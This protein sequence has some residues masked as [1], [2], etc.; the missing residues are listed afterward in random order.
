MA[1]SKL[2]RGM[3]RDGS[4]RVLVIDSTEIVRSAAAVHHTSPT[5]TAALGRLLTAASMLGSMMGEKTDS[6]T[7]GINGDGAAGKMIAVADYYG[8]V[9]GYMENPAVDPP[10]CGDGK[11]DVGGAVGRGVLYVIR[12]EGQGEP[13]T[14]MIALKSGEI[15]EDI[16][17][18]Y[19]ESEQIPTV[20]ALGVLVDRD[21]TCRAAGGVLIQLL[22]FPAEQTVAKLEENARKLTNVSSMI[23]SGMTPHQ[24]MESVMDGIA[25]D[26]FDEIDVEYLCTCSRERME[27]G[28]LS[29]GEKQVQDLLSEQLAEGKPDALTAT[30]RF[31][32]AEYTYT[33]AELDAGF[34]KM[35]EQ[36]T[37]QENLSPADQSGVS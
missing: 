21:R 1:L 8:N 25:Y 26:P 22:P 34:R 6:L 14:G 10:V 16:A 20:C 23:D 15:A 30:C 5:A 18:Y 28:L 27:R 3:T 17:A 2:M 9:R 7:V 35:K 11:L 32:N 36:Q 31:C 24:I 13:Q 12:S 33:R 29:L 19:A 4:A 37:A